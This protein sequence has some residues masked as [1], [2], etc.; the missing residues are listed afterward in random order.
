MYDKAD[1]LVRA[2]N[3]GDGSVS[4]RREKFVPFGGPDGGD[5][6]NG[7]DVVIRADAA[8]DDLRKYRQKRNYKAEHGAN[9]GNQK[10]HGRNGENL[11]L[12]VPAGTIV[13]TP[14]EEG[15]P[16]LLADLE[17]PGDEVIV[18]TG[19]SGG[20]A[21][22]HFTSS[23]NQAPHIAQRGEFGEEL[24][25]GLEMRLIADVGIVGYPNAGKS[26]LLAAASAAR[27]KIAGYPFTTLEPIL[28]VVEVGMESFVMAEIPGLIEGAHA[29]RGLGHE[30]LRHAMRTRIFVH[31]VS[32]DAESPVDDML[33]INEELVRFDPVL[34]ARPQIIAVNKI[35]MPDVQA[36]LPE[37]KQELGAA[38]VDA[39]YISA[40]TGE[41][42]PDL[43]AETLALLREHAEA[44][45]QETEEIR[46]FRPKPREER[47]A[48]TRGE[49]GAWTVHAPDLERLYA[50]AGVAPGELRGQIIFQL[51]RVGALKA[52]EKAGVNKGDTVLCG[53]VRWEW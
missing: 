8:V 38:G 4:F 34:A 14:D 16:C 37:L 35:D 18:A 19:G 20:R 41:G 52:L 47:Y 44:P 2:G 50:A 49:D 29:G 9:G 27:P 17:K 3:G 30:F 42:V 11:V 6:G 28:G 40:E 10:K 23:V 5:G 25:I 33:N 53:E 48:V 31:L 21:N 7:G 15:R 39:R 12:P 13:T 43:M 24:E 51:Q 32:G 36:R 45:P 26:T 22:I 46:I 1:I